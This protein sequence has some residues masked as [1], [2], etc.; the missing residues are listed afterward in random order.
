M[1]ELILEPRRTAVVVIDLQKGIVG[2]P[3]NPHSASS[4]IANS[5]AL[6]HGGD[7]A[8][9]RERLRRAEFT[10]VLRGEELSTAYANMD[11][12]V[13]PSHTD[14]FGNVVLEALASGVPAR[15]SPSPTSPAA[16]ASPS[17]RSWTTMPPLA[18]AYAG[19]LTQLTSRPCC[20]AHWSTSASWAFSSSQRLL[21]SRCGSTCPV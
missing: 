5:V 14:T 18:P 13:F 9:L 15:S 17:K 7:E 4:V 3:G 20:P 6:L 11:L 2:F 8:W 16:C 21:S 1:S 19:G 10:G 12:F